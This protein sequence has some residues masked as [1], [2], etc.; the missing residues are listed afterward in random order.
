MTNQREIKFVLD[1]I[2]ERA[3]DKNSEILD[4]DFVHVHSGVIKAAKETVW[5]GWRG[6]LTTTVLGHPQWKWPLW[7]RGQF[8][9][10]SAGYSHIAHSYGAGPTYNR[11]YRS[12]SIVGTPEGEWEAIV[13]K[14]GSIMPRPE[15]YA[16]NF[17]VYL[18][19]KLLAVGEEGTLSQR[20]MEGYLP[21]IETT[22]LLPDVRI[23]FL[24]FA[25]K[26][27]S[28]DVCFTRIQMTNLSEKVK[29]LSLFAVVTPWGPFQ[30]YPVSEVKYSSE[31]CTFTVEGKAAVVF[32]NQ[33][34]SYGCSN[35]ED[36]YVCEDASDGRLEGNSI[37]KCPLGFA[38]GA[39]CFPVNLSPNEDKVLDVKQLVDSVDL[40]T[41]LIT[42][43]RSEDTDS[44]LQGVKEYWE[45]KLKGKM[46]INIPDNLA[47]EALKSAMVDLLL[48]KNGKN[49]YAGPIRY[50]G[51]W[52]R[53][54][55]HLLYAM[56]MAGFHEE[57]HE[58]MSYF[59][60]AQGPDGYFW[61]TTV[62][63][64]KEDKNLKEF[65]SYGEAVWSM[66][67]HYRFNKNREWLQRMYPLMKK[68][69]EFIKK[70]R[71]QTKVL[72]EGKEP[73]NYGLL[74]ISWSAEHTGPPDNIYYDD[75]WTV[76]GLKSAIFAAEELGMSEDV[77]SMKK[78]CADLEKCLWNSIDRTI[79]KKGLPCFPASPYQEV[80]STIIGNIAALWPCKIVESD[81]KRINE[82]LEVLYSKHMPNYCWF[83]DI[84]G[85][86]GPLFT[87]SIAN[88]FVQK[89]DVDKVAKIFKWTLENGQTAT[90]SSP[91]GVHPKTLEGGEG[92]GLSGWAHAEYIM[93]IRNM[94]LL[95]QDESLWI[96]PCLLPE[97][98]SE[99]TSIGIQNTSSTFGQVGYSFSPDWV[100]GCITVEMDFKGDLPKNGFKLFADHPEGKS[101]K[102]VM[103]DGENWHQF[104]SSKVNISKIFKTVEVFF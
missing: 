54:R 92:D 24:S 62:P 22:W 14:D 17:W 7:V 90:H 68:G 51:D 2:T 15:T 89:R 87:W 18:D 20:R 83:H 86:Y 95:E 31:L 27:D 42:K 69:T 8:D 65:D 58:C 59:E 36:G 47:F 4:D 3:L 30:F 104:E 72:E 97:W 76:C 99:N 64:Y 96:A 37:G 100:G 102:R 94:L 44:H 98:L 56:E 25:D 6:L 38:S 16:L 28:K 19:G 39:A 82:V 26:V 61:H 71:L 45:N 32:E 103:V 85:S 49:I 55:A 34:E 101:I 60:E 1:G 88:C 5:T 33:P 35:Y 43:I 67:Q 40:D 73:L 74:P 66:V 50:H 52:I 75:I 12:F 29:R 70:L 93:L 77:I 80:T 78:E 63:L 57:V 23:T 53:D 46:V 48:L 91:E 81:N 10:Q 21:V 84:W 9:M 11:A 13:G 41:Q 79:E